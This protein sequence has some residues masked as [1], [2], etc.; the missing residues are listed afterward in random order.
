MST[1]V[2]LKKHLQTCVIDFCVKKNTIF[3]KMSLKTIHSILLCKYSYI[4]IYCLYSLHV[5]LRIQYQCSEV[6]LLFTSAVRQI[7][8]KFSIMLKFLIRVRSDVTQWRGEKLGRKQG[9]G[10]GGLICRE[11]SVLI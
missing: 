8:G 2:S 10:R 9:G 4:Y 5:S 1:Y 11:F 3:S 6:M 7:P